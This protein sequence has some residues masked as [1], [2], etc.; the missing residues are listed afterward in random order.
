MVSVKIDRTLASLINRDIELIEGIEHEREHA[1][2]Y[3]YIKKHGLP[4]PETFYLMIAKA[5]IDET[6][7]Y[8]K[9]LKKAGL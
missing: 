7:Y 2:L 8:Y 9:R 4:S 3:K 1:D 6:P 5:H